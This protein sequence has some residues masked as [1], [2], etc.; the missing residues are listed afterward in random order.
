MV[1]NLK[2]RLPLLAESVGVV[3]N[4][5]CDASKFTLSTTIMALGQSSKEINGKPTEVVLQSFVDSCLVLVTQMG[6]V[7][8]L[9]RILL[10]SSGK[11]TVNCEFQS[12]SKPPFLPRRLLSPT[13]QKV[14]TTLY[15]NPLLLFNYQRCSGAR[16]PSTRRSCTHYTRPRLRQSS[17]PKRRKLGWIVKALLLVLHC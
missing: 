6:K 17:G 9:V 8:N 10:L 2:T 11:R 16:L 12:R 13:F 3:Q 1:F 15:L 5:A 4:N 7:G 14:P